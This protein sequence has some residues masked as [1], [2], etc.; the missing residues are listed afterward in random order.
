MNNYFRVLDSNI[1]I[2]VIHGYRLFHQLSAKI[3]GKTIIFTLQQYRCIIGRSRNFIVQHMKQWIKINLHLK[4]LVT[5]ITG[6]HACCHKFERKSVYYTS[7]ITTRNTK[8]YSKLQFVLYFF[9][10]TQFYRVLLQKTKENVL[11]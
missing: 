9:L 3:Q 2:A 6:Q 7:P 5:Y 10:F 1:S 8:I 11:R 4:I